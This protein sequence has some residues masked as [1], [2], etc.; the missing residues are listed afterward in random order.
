MARG[1]ITIPKCSECIEYLY[2]FFTKWFKP[3]V[4]KCCIHGILAR[5]RGV[6]W[7]FVSFFMTSYVV[8][9]AFFLPE[10]HHLLYTSCLPKAPA[11]LSNGYFRQSRCG[12]MVAGYLPQP[13][14]SDLLPKVNIAPEKFPGPN[15][16]VLSSNLFRGWSVEFQGCISWF[17]LVV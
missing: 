16:K 7:Q 13:V 5:N 14:G 10:R 2:V 15:R 8:V 6:T 9:C 11:Q 17:M 3:N 1:D 12:N 4:G